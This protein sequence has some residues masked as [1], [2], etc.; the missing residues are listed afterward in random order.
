MDAGQAALEHVL[1]RG[2]QPP[3]DVVL[4]EAGNGPAD[5]AHRA[6]DEDARRLAPIVADDLT[7]G[8]ADESFVTLARRIAS[9]LAQPAWP[10]TR[11]SQTGRS[12]ATASSTAAVGNAPPGQRL[13]S[14]FRPVIQR[15][16]GVASIRSLTRRAT[17]SSD[18]TPRRSSSS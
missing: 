7:V 12:G 4:R 17:S 14:Q 9:E 11:L 18:A 15:S 16:P 13:W 8:G 10:S 6:V 1:L 3:F 2:E 5:Q